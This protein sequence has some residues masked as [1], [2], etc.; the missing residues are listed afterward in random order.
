MNCTEVTELMQRYL[1]EDLNETEND[2]L[3]RHLSHCSNCTEMFERLRRLSD[4]L[5]NLPK[6]TPPYSIVDSIMPQLE[7]LDK[8]PQDEIAAKYKQRKNSRHLSW[9]WFGGV[10][11]AGLVFGMFIF[12]QSF[13]P[14]HNQGQFISSGIGNQQPAE[15]RGLSG[16]PES[17]AGM[18]GIASLTHDGD[19]MKAESNSE[20]MEVMPF[21]SLDTPDVSVS[22]ADV[23]KKATTDTFST[24][25]HLGE[26]DPQVVDQYGVL[27]DMPTTSE[28]LSTDGVYLAIVDKGRVIIREVESQQTIYRSIFQWED[29]VELLEWIDGHYLI[30]EVD[31][32]NAPKQILIDVG[33][34]TEATKIERE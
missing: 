17:E 7:Q 33:Q 6:V 16:G 9:K 31:L 28:L 30:Y 15:N 27:Q 25:G 20:G 23:K 32:A 26:V 2:D 11:A 13:A 21:R 29:E 22:D 19:E 8:V 10:V 4:D 1:D 34:K 18:M 24:A 5:A 14:D 12:N 3:Q